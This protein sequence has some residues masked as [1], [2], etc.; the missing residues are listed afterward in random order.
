MDPLHKDQWSP[1]FHSNLLPIGRAS[2]QT[3]AVS[4]PTAWA[5]LALSLMAMAVAN[6]SWVLASSTVF[7]DNGA[8]HYSH[9]DAVLHVGESALAFIRSYNSNDTRGG[10]LGFGWTHNFQMRLTHSPDSQD[11]GLELADGET[12]VFEHLPDGS[13]ASRQGTAETLVHTDDGYE[14]NVEG[15]HVTF[16]VNGRMVAVQTGSQPP[17]T[18]TQGRFGPTQ[19]VDAHG[20]TV[21]SFTYGADTGTGARLLSVTDHPDLGRGPADPR[22]IRFSYD[23]FGRLTSVTDRANRTTT[24]TYPVVVSALTRIVDARGHTAVSIVYDAEGRVVARTDARGLRTGWQN[25]LAYTSTEGAMTSEER[26]LPSGLAPDWQPLETHV[27]DAHGWALTTSI[28]PGPNDEPEEYAWTWRDD[29]QN[30]T[31]TRTGG[32]TSAPEGALMDLDTRPAGSAAL[33]V[34]DPH[35]AVPQPSCV[36]APGIPARPSNTQT[37]SAPT[38]EYD[39]R[40]DLTVR[41][42]SALVGVT[43]AQLDPFGRPVAFQ[44]AEGGAWQLT[45]DSEDRLTQ[46]DE[47]SGLGTTIGY[48]EVGNVTSLE[49]SAGNKSAFAYDERDKLVGATWSAG[50]SAVYEYDERGDLY[51]AELRSA[52]SGVLARAAYVHDGLHRIRRVERD[53]PELGPHTV[54]VIAFGYGDDG[55][56]RAYRSISD[57]STIGNGELP[58]SPTPPALPPEAENATTGVHF[59]GVS[60][61]DGPAWFGFVRTAALFELVA[62]ILAAFAGLIVLGTRRRTALV[63]RSGIVGSVG[64]GLV[65]LAPGLMATL[66]LYQAWLSFPAP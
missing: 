64:I 48:D 7:T 29:G 35:Q 27:S 12:D 49:D 44:D 26:K 40:T 16:D 45:F 24:H 11:L 14:A 42:A 37:W 28:R 20:E 57:V 6:P 18:V 23:F 39:P 32:G 58:N 19:V 9:T 55:S 38:T 5:P 43:H 21:L 1:Q 51:R 61:S 22:R 25:T 36:T 17:L 3:V 65:S 41:I 4:R 63:R 56:C 47:P 46:V 59:T 30:L 31:H 60:S 10:G 62:L 53:A 15:Q 33:I 52:T 50:N 54:Q 2:E 66:Q 8:Y 13:Y 34:G